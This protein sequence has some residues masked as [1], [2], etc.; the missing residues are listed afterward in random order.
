MR[1]NLKVI[2]SVAGVA[3][4]LAAP[5]MAQVVD[6]VE[7]QSGDHG[8]HN[9]N[10]WPAAATHTMSRLGLRSARKLTGTDFA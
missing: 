3:A 6:K 2:L 7:Q 9:I 5:A 10:A 1:T 8:E 4:L